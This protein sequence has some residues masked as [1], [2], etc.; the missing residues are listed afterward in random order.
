MLNMI[1]DGLIQAD[2]QNAETYRANAAAY[3]K[4]LAA[5]D[6]YI[7]QQIATLPPEKRKLVSDHDTFGYYTERYGLTFIGSVI[8]SLS[9]TEQPSAQ[10]IADLIEKI[11]AEKVKAIFTES[12]INP[13][14]AQQISQET[15][16]KIVQGALYGDTLG[17]PGSGADTLD[18]MLK[19]NTDLIVANLR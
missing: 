13:E 7:M 3:E 15:G 4:K 8:S 14:L 1:R 19:L 2:P 10:Q 12:S 18:G 9:T 5:L 6:Q 17:L 11:R 16:I